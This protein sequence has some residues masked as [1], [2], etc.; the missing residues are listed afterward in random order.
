MQLQHAVT[1]YLRLRATHVSP[2]WSGGYTLRR[3]ARVIGPRRELDSIGPQEIR[4][5]LDGNR[6]LTRYWHGKYSALGKFFRF[7]LA[8]GFTTQFALPTRAPKCVQTFRPYIYPQEQ[9]RRLINVSSAPQ[10]I[11]LKI[12][13][14]TFRMLVLLLYGTG[15][16]LGEALRLTHADLDVPQSRLTVRGTKFYKTRW[17]PLGPPL[18]RLLQAYLGAEGRVYLPDSSHHVLAYRDGRPMQKSAVQRAF[19]RVIRQAGITRDD[20]PQYRP[21]IHDLRATFAVHRLTSWYREGADVQQL[22][23][24]LSTYLGH[25]SLQATQVYLT[26]TPELLEQAS[27]RFERFAAAR[28]DHD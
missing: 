2:T 25:G 24:L 17:V 15:L 4:R 11:W 19:A 21:R 28:T 26:M 3:F 6:P 5:F 13:P 14:S 9:I 8:R 23:P 1:S 22:L 27:I 20:Q 18:M 12:R 16:R 7:A 10:L